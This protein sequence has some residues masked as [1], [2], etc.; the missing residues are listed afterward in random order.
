MI[1]DPSSPSE[2]PLI[3]AKKSAARERVLRHVRESSVS[4]LTQ[5]V[6]WVLNHFPEARNSDVTLQLRYWETFDEGYHRGDHI[7][8]DEL[9][10]L[11]RL[12]SLSRARATV[13]NDY[14]LF[15]SSPEI[16]KHRGKLSDEELERVR[17]E[18]PT[19]PVISVYADESGKAEPYLVV[20]S[21]WILDSFSNVT[22]YNA[23]NDVRQR[24]GYHNEFH[25]KHVNAKTLPA[26][27]ELLSRF[28]EFASVMSGK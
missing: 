12:T 11:P 18:K 6:A 14:H 19:Y 21:V 10:R 26:Y 27:L 5:R 16:R 2:A 1:E 15:L 17:V 3:D 24:H 4:T 8:P 7:S 13:Q 28:H 23:V 25:F 9:Y 20:G 22:L